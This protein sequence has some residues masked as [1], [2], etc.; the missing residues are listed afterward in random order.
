M[1][2][3]CP[4]DPPRDPPGVPETSLKVDRRREMP[5]VADPMP[6]RSGHPT[7]Q[8]RRSPPVGLP[9]NSQL[10]ALG[11]GRS[12]HSPPFGATTRLRV[13]VTYCLRPGGVQTPYSPPLTSPTTG[14]AASSSGR[15][16]R[17]AR[18]APSRPGF[19]PRPT[20]CRPYGASRHPAHLRLNC[21]SA[22]PRERPTRDRSTSQ[23]AGN[24]R[25]A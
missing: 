19:A 4:S 25:V 2:S 23:A 21:L 6:P 22:S 8:V 13:R 7:L 15:E 16:P 18:E 24:R 5:H 14:A 11:A 17:T 20:H 3:I 10:T 1:I 12:S 9:V